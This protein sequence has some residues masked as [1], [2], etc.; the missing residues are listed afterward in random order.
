MNDTEKAPK[1]MYAF[2][3]MSKFDIEKLIN[4]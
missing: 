4:A 1:V 3:Q 2:M